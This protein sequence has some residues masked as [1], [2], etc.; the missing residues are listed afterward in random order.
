[1]KKRVLSI[2]LTIFVCLI[3]LI[4]LAYLVLG[5]AV[6]A[7]AHEPVLVSGQA[8][9][10]TTDGW[11]D[12]YKCDCGKF[13]EDEDGKKEITDL[14]TWK[15]GDG[16]LEKLPHEL[17]EWTVETPATETAEGIEKRVCSVC[18][19]EETREIPKLDAPKP[20]EPTE[21]EEPA[22]PGTPDN[23]PKTGDSGR[24][25]MW[26]LITTAC[27]GGAV[28]LNMNDKKKHAIK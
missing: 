9:T 7:H 23:V 16:K 24:L 27:L 13:F 18:G 20:E 3:F 11:K 10:C 12:Y 19:Y 2:V 8:A 26:S 6:K 21:P 25:V 1:M 5:V 22:K 15:T 14:N 17:G 4:C 28:V